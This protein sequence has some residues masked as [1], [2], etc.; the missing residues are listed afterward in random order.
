M[1]H[2]LASLW[3]HSGR[4]TFYESGGAFGQSLF[5]EHMG[6]FGHAAGARR[7]FKSADEAYAYLRFWMGEPAAR[8]ELQWVLQRSGPSLAT[9][10]AG[11]D[12]WLHALAGR[13]VNGAVIVYE[14]MSRQATPGRLVAPSTASAM[15]A[16][17]VADLPVLAALPPTVPVVENLLPALEDIRIEGAEVLPELNQSL[18]QVQAAIGTVSEASLSLDPAP[19]K[20]AAIQSEITAAASKASSTLSSL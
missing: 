2:P 14:E 19:S 9:A 12:G 4:V 5:Q 18:D 13:L 7:R 16:A 3:R 20:V 8:A 6:R 10:R 11:V 1:L 15:S 17:A